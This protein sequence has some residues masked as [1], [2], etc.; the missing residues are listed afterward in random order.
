MHAL[1]FI[2][3][4][5][6]LINCPTAAF[7]I[8]LITMPG[9]SITGV[10]IFY[11]V[12]IMTGAVERIKK[13]DL[14]HLLIFFIFLLIQ[15]FSFKPRIVIQDT[16]NNFILP[17]MVLLIVGSGMLISLIYIIISLIKIREHSVNIQNYFSA[18]EKI[19][20][21]WFINI[22]YFPI[23]F[24]SVSVAGFLITFWHKPSWYVM[25]SDL[26]IF[27]LMLFT[28]AFY[29]I[30]QPERLKEK[31]NAIGA[32]KKA[33]EKYAKYKLNIE[34]QKKYL[35][36]L[37]EYMEQNKPYLNGSISIRELAEELKIPYYYIS[38]VIN[39]LLK[40]N[41]YDY[42]NEYRIHEVVRIFK[43]TEDKDTA[44]ILTIAFE[45][46]FNS[47]STFNSVFKKIMGTTP[48][49]FRDNLKS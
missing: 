16:L 24:L 35:K 7:F 20:M 17:R 29:I 26:I 43:K 11:Y 31:S 47:K 14:S 19:D 12:L 42:I 48:S 49:R 22:L 40:K 36:L 9:Y 41:F 28:S 34:D 30:N 23:L 4:Y 13:K 27:I 15:I 5:L 1:S 10:F 38:I 21:K 37:N 46:G 39:N 18:I 33:K 32:N 44:N 25:I 45:C 3:H 8:S 2:P 6:W